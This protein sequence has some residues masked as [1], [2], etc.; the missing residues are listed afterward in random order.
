MDIFKSF[1]IGNTT[2][3]K[4]GCL[5]YKQT[6]LFGCSGMK[7]VLLTTKIDFGIYYCQLSMNLLYFKT[8]S[9]I[10]KGQWVSSSIFNQSCAVLMIHNSSILK[11]IVFAT[12]KHQA[13][14]SPKHRSQ[15]G[16]YNCLH[17]SMKLVYYIFTSTPRVVRTHFR[18][19][20]RI[21]VFWENQFFP[22]CGESKN[23]FDPRNLTRP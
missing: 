8:S 17:C 22:F 19:N 1:G 21:Q 14:I 9:S 11:H 5:D 3:R 23:I 15:R 20:P 2:G 12:S 7:I 4:C 6:K 13:L 10:V 18:T 16:S